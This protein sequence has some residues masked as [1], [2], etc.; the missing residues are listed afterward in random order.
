MHRLS[1]SVMQAQFQGALF[2]SRANKTVINAGY[3]WANSGISVRRFWV[4]HW[5]KPGKMSERQIRLPCF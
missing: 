4:R 5:K 2:V 1:D 3:G